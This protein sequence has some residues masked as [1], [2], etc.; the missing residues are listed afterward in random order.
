LTQASDRVTEIL[1]ERFHYPSSRI[2]NRNS[3]GLLFVM[4]HSSFITQCHHRIHSSCTARGDV[5][6][7]K[8]YR[9]EE[10]RYHRKSHLV[11]RRHTV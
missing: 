11:C 10:K 5:T 6:G 8:R 4:H 3:R 2:T 7:Q 9:C 1:P